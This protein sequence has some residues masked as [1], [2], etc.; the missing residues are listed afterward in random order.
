MYQQDF[1]LI[2]RPQDD[3]SSKVVGQENYQTAHQ[4]AVAGTAERVGQ[5]SKYTQHC[6]NV[7][8]KQAR[9]INYGTHSKIPSVGPVYY[10]QIRFGKCYKPGLHCT[11]KW[12]G[13]HY[14]TLESDIQLP[15]SPF[16]DT[17]HCSVMLIIN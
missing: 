6:I 1:D 2:D 5:Y 14:L 4:L 12:L 13:S 17:I 9:I 15:K 3:R 7:K 10:G 11:C 8:S 16:H